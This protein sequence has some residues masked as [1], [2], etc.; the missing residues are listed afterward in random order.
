MEWMERMDGTEWMERMDGTE[1][2]ERMDRTKWMEWNGNI[3]LFS[4]NAK[5]EI[6]SKIKW[7][8]ENIDT[9]KAKIRLKKYIYIRKT[10]PH[11]QSPT[12]LHCAKHFLLLF[13]G[14]YFAVCPATSG[15]RAP[16]AGQTSATAVCGHFFCLLLVG[17]DSDLNDRSGGIFGRPRLLLGGLLL[18]LGV[19][20][21]SAALLDHTGHELALGLGRG[22]LGPLGAQAQRRKL[23]RVQPEVLFGL[24][25]LFGLFGVRLAALLALHDL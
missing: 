4:K 10:R 2:M 22:L 6:K 11:V 12:V 13:F 19:F 3:M 20:F 7:I 17:L 14:T 23:V 15:A 9:K 16:T 1:W 21:V 24:G 18:L 25:L 8:H 5:Y